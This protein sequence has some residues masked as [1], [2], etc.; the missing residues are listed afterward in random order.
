MGSANQAFIGPC[1]AITYHAM[2]PPGTTQKVVILARLALA[3]R[4][5]F[6]TPL[7]TP[8]TSVTCLLHVRTRN[9]ILV[10]YSSLHFSGLHFFAVPVVAC[11]CARAGRVG[12]NDNCFHG[13]LM[14]IYRCA[15]V[16]CMYLANGGL[17][18]TILYDFESFIF[19]EK[20][21]NSGS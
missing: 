9:Q 14:T 18:W 10:L 21:L 19:F 11:C 7:H 13:L 12:G 5:H 16:F 20:S 1:R 3:L 2:V 8:Y 4:C 17:N 15:M 6:Y